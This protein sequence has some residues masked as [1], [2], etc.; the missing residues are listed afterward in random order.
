LGGA[1]V[2]RLERWGEA[3]PPGYRDRY[4][5]AEALKD[6]AAIEDLLSGGPPVRVRP[7][8]LEDD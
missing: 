3:F 4:D 2:E 5:A 7:Y 6:A 8:R 1:V